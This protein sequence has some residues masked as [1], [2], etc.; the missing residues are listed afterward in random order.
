MA[1]G[2]I[3]KKKN[4]KDWYTDIIF[5]GQRKREK[6]GKKET[7]QKVL[8]HKLTELTLEEH[9][10]IEDEKVTLAEF[11]KEYLIHKK[12]STRPSTYIRDEVSVNLHLVPYFGKEY[13]FNITPHKIFSYQSKRLSE[14]VLNATINREVSCLKHLLNTAITWRRI[15]TNP[16]KD[17]PKLKEPPGRIR[18]LT[19]EEINTLL[20]ACP[21][22]P[23]RLRAVV[24]IA[25]TTGMRKG[26]ILGLKWSF[27]K[28]DSRFIILPVTK[29][30]TV[31]ILPMNDAVI[32]EL[33][34]LPRDSEYV[35]GN[36]T[37]KHQG[38][39]KRSFGTACEAAGSKIFVPRP[40]AHLREPSGHEGG[41]HEG[42]A[43][44]VRPQGYQDDSAVFPSFAGSAPGSGETH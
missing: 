21:K 19:L 14:G 1:W 20:L 22:P 13:L 31:R 44:A 23:H 29:N 41:P 32:R 6:I 10:I 2:R 27:I 28:F 35:F 7:A 36:G 30:N 15:K 37:G 39:I 42:P 25:L 3:F 8:N 9:G 4:G 40:P 17:V 43:G 26:E 12:N 11:A 33:E 5:Q 16:I 18:Y 34:G 24:T 38:D